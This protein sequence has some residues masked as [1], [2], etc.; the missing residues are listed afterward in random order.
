MT[1]KENLIRTIRRDHPEWIPY[2]YDGS[3][4]MVYPLM[5]SR[6]REGGLDDWGV[7]WVA[8]NTEEGS[9]PDERVYLSID[10]PQDIHVPELDWDG[11][12]AD[13]KKTL[14]SHQ[15]EDT[16]VIVRNEVLIFERAKLL[17]GTP[18]CLMAFLTDAPKMHQLLDILTEFQIKLAHAVM[19]S[20]VAGMRFT[21]DWGMQ[22]SL[23]IHPDQWRTFIKPRLKKIY[24]VVKA[25]QGFVFQHSC[26][27]IDEIVPDL[28][29]VGTDVLDPC[30]P[31]S[32]DIFRWKK[33]YGGQLSFMGALDTQ[34]YLSFGTPEAIRTS[35]RQVL[36]IMGQ[37]GG[38]I[39]APSHTISLPEENKRAMEETIKE[40]SQEAKTHVI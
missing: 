32:N 5:S 13:L 23:F 4:T 37:G 8:T 11:I 7:Q 40:F 27:H 17:L 20:G 21:D 16:L 1:K 26:G 29:E 15:G 34:G 33:E 18:E 10:R 2:R 3:L 25:Y 6:P 36:R 38:F 22:N 35:V 28:I 24:D 9:Y 31:K 19:K 14:A 39:A 30:Q 12:T